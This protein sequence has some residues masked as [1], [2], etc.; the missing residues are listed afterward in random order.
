M[1]IT[2]LDINS[3]AES[4]SADTSLVTVL[5]HYGYHTKDMMHMKTNSLE[6]AKWDLVSGLCYNPILGFIKASMI[7]LY[8]RLG[9]TKKGVRLACYGLLTLTLSLTLALDLADAFECTPVAY[10]WN[11]RA[12][13]LAAQKAQNATEQ[14][15]IP[16]FGYITGFKNGKYVTGGHCFDRAMFIMVAAGLAILTDLMILCIPVYMVR[17]NHD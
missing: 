1:D 8:L 11:S 2:S 7:L 3:T 12:M 16:G 15:F 9:G 17:N 13:D 10:V 6:I 5:S 14:K 4:N